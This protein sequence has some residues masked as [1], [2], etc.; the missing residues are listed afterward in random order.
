MTHHPLRHP[1]KAIARV[2][3]PVR[4]YSKGIA[5]AVH[6]GTDRP[7]PGEDATAEIIDVHD[8]D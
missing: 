8:L 4:T 5:R 3:A 1:D 7:P 6:E 2:N